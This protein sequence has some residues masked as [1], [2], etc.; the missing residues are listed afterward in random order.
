MTVELASSAA[1]VAPVPISGVS[2]PQRTL[3]GRNSAF[4]VA[5]PLYA[6]F[7]LGASWAGWI[8]SDVFITSA[9]FFILVMGMDLL[10]GCAG[11]LSFGH[12]G[13]F[14][15]GAYSVAALSTTYGFDLWTATLGGILINI[16]VSYL[17]GRICLRLSGSYFMLGTLA[18]GI[19]VHASITVGYTVTGGDV[20]LGG[21]ARPIIAGVSLSTDK[22]FG[23]LAWGVAAVIF[24][25]TLTLSGSRAGRALRAVRSDPVAAAC[26]GVNVDRVKTNIFLLSAVYASVAGSLFAMYHGAVHP[27]SFSLGV[28]LNVLLMMFLGGEGTI[29]GGLIGATFI[30]IL[31]DI[32]GSFA[33]AKDLF[34]G[35]L[36]SVIIFLFPG[37][38][39]GAIRDGFN[40]RAR[41]RR[42]ADS[43]ESSLAVRGDVPDL[44]LAPG[45]SGPA[46]VVTDIHKAF[47]GV[48][49]VDGVSFDVA[50]GTVKGL[51]GP[52]GAG[53]STMM[54][55][56]SGVLPADRG[57]VALG[58]TKLAGLR[59]DET[60]RIGIQRT[61]QHERLFSHLT[62]VENVM[63]G[64]E[65]GI[66]GSVGSILVC[67]LAL[68]STLKADAVARAEA[69]EWLSACGL[70]AHAESSVESLP[71]GLRK[72]VEVARACAAKPSV[73]LLD[74]TAAGLNETERAAF[75]QIVRKLRAAGL[76]TVLIEHDIDLVMELCDDICV[77]NFGRRIADGPPAHVRSHEEVIAAYLGA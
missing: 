69:L 20:G 28:L 52:N 30:S 76:T 35:I 62:V 75:K 12:V 9:I 5:L 7:A 6:I 14:A 51:I 2:Q 13:F 58:T 45:A 23:A 40:R 55:L 71:H 31:P 10:Y 66:D 34:N 49:A 57:S 60:A 54:N 43:F 59:P 44:G 16:V 36:F 38:V 72:L 50:R 64:A 29:W 53:K 65:R 37:G 25:L 73:L 68:P 17:L 33:A 21:I 48:K 4:M 3:L 56:I 1:R 77:I 39:G 47:G 15:I 63:V 41:S 18:F 61:F 22:S 32:S 11:M 27:D 42:D 74:E 46:L 24:W 8:H 70:A 67:A 26:L 19:M